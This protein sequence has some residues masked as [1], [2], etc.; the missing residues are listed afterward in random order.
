MRRPAA[1]AMLAGF[2]GLGL[3]L[4]AC[5][6]TAG[7]SR[8]TAADGVVDVVAST[9]VYG[10]IVSSIGGDKVRVSSIINR[11]SQDPH[12]YE[13]TTQDKLAVSKAELVVE[14]GGGYDAFIDTLATDTGLDRGS[15]INAVDVAGVAS[16]SPAA[17]SPDSSGHAHEHA[18]LN[19]H[20]WYSLPAMSRLA[21]AVADK[22]GALEPG[23]A[24]TFRRNA[25]AFKDSLGGLE[26]KLAAIKAS[27]GHTPV[28]VTEPVPLYLLEDA[29]LENETPAEYTAAIE[30]DADVPPAVLKAAVDLVASR[31]VRLLAYNTQTEGPQTVALKNAA[32]TA[33]VPVVNFSETLPD[34]QSYVQWMTGNV[35]S[36]SKALG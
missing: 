25:A 5:S 29:G 6:P 26:A 7:S 2:A 23:S 15:V 27:A 19:E 32:K 16:E 12:S 17:A 35:E 31:G 3:L 1:R 9:S 13:A 10:D 30:E 18:G 34:G 20:V 21:D 22:L 14:N 4:T 11:T 36:I 8:G 24:E 33:G 28:A